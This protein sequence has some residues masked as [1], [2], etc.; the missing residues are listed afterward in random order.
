[1]SKGGKKEEMRGG[2]EGEGRNICTNYN[3]ER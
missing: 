1:M 2:R 3:L